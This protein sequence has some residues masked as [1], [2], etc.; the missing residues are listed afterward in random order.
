MCP[1]VRLWTFSR[2]QSW[3]LFF[4]VFLVKIIHVSDFFTGLSFKLRYYP[5]SDS[6]TTLCALRL[7]K[8]SVLLRGRLKT[9]NQVRRLKR[10]FYSCSFPKWSTAVLYEIV[11]QL[12]ANQIISKQTFLRFTRFT[13]K[14]PPLLHDQTFIANVLGS[15]DLIGCQVH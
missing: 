2:I 6:R 12:K 13:L 11:I 8:N 7:L 14:N 4:L 15:C 5:N 10:N 9:L 1:M 3:W